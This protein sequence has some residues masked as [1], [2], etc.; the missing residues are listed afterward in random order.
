VLGFDPHLN[1]SGSTGDRVAWPNF[2]TLP[3]L[4]CKQ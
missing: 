4:L 2:A 3:K 1:N